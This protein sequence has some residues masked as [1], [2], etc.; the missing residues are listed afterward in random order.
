MSDEVAPEGWVLAARTADPTV[1]GLAP[2]SYLQ[3][4]QEKTV[5]PPSPGEGAMVLAAPTTLVTSE[6]I[7]AR[8]AALEA[9]EAAMRARAEAEAELQ[10]RRAALDEREAAVAAREARAREAA[11]EQRE[12]AVRPTLTPTLAP[13]RTPTPNHSLS[14]NPSPSLEANL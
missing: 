2:R 4:L 6:S 11:L 13:T 1:V 3:R 14:H 8:E 12:A 10:R 9:A 5:P 7:R